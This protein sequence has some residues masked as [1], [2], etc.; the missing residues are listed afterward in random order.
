V[1]HKYRPP[2][3]K[4]FDAA[5]SVGSCAVCGKLSFRSKAAAKRNI[6]Q[7]GDGFGSARAYLCESGYWHMTS[8]D[9]ASIA[10]LREKQTPAPAPDPNAERAAVEIR[11]AI[12]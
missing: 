9:A 5:A 4:P 8:M 1:A 3:S 7:W 10:D 6:R 2:R 11:R 12:G